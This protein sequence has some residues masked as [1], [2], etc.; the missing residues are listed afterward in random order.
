MKDDTPAF[1]YHYTSI[2]NLALILSH[3]TIRFRQ[4]S[5]LNDPLEGKNADF[6]YAEKLIFSSSWTASEQDS[7]PMWSLYTGLKGVRVKL[8]IDLFNPRDEITYGKWGNGHINAA[9]ISPPIEMLMLPTQS[10]R[11]AVHKFSHVTG[12]DKINYINSESVGDLP[13]VRTKTIGFWHTAK[14]PMEGFD[15]S[16]IGLHKIED[17]SFEHEWRFRI[18]LAIQAT[19]EGNSL[20][21]Y[22]EI[23]QP[24]RDY[25]D[26]PIRAEALQQIEVMLG[27][28]T[29]QGEEVL[30]R[31]LINTIVPSG[32]ITK[33]EIQIR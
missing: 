3:R 28:K 14:N 19:I 18:P 22:C 24:S 9:S 10:G 1:L 2:E 31:S 6:A 33:S 4:L 15:L 5:T 8:P 7:I 20:E 27:P 21:E 13:P 25:I 23:M 11:R 32:K 16:N 26:L 12:P 30:V 17:W 29:T